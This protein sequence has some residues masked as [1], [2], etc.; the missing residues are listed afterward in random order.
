MTKNEYRPTKCHH[1]ECA[2]PFT[3]CEQCH[4][5]VDSPV[6][7][8]RT[9]ISPREFYK[10]ARKHSNNRPVCYDHVL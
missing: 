4:Y 8:P 7:N 9:F 2:Y 6:Y 5:N 3:V 1:K 10:F